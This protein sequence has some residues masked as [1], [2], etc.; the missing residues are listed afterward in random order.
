M[1]AWYS[2][3]VDV[4]QSYGQWLESAC[5]QIDVAEGVVQLEFLVVSLLEGC[6]HVGAG[7]KQDSFPT[8]GGQ[9]FHHGELAPNLVVQGVDPVVFGQCFPGG[10]RVD[11]PPELSNRRHK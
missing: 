9:G 6:A 10:F 5:S 11:V 8:A 1:L 3:D 4:M 7:K 2:L